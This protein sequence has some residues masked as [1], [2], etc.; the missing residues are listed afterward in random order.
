M[1]CGCGKKKKKKKNKN[2]DDEVYM[3]SSSSSKRTSVD[4]S[5]APMTPPTKKSRF[6]RF[7][8]VVTRIASPSMKRSNIN[9]N[10]GVPHV[11]EDAIENKDPPASAV[12][13]MQEAERT[14]IVST[15]DK[16]VLKRDK[17]PPAQDNQ[18]RVTR[19]LTP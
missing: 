11:Q 3:P 8:R 2:E 4:A 10:Q 19:Y 17:L 5:K 9:G 12:L 15:E 13:T 7:E 1:F 14:S 6:E 18:V 16:T